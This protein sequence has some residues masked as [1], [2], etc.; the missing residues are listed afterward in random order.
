ML[1][2]FDK[3]TNGQPLVNLK[4]TTGEHWWANLLKFTDLPFISS[5]EVP[6]YPDEDIYYIVDPWNNYASFTQPTAEKPIY[7]IPQLIIDNDVTVLFLLNETIFD[8]DEMYARIK[9]AANDR[10]IK[11]FFILTTNIYMSEK[12]HDVFYYSYFEDAYRYKL[13]DVDI[14]TEI[15][16]KQRKKKF[17]LLNNIDKWERRIFSAI[18]ESHNL[19]EHGYFSYLRNLYN[20]P[21]YQ[22]IKRNRLVKDL[23]HEPCYE[24]ILKLDD[25]MPIFLEEEDMDVAFKHDYIPKY[26]Y[27][28][29]YWNLVVETSNKTKSMAFTE[30]TWKPI[31][32]LQP[33]ILLSGHNSL[34]HLHKLGYRTFKH[35]IDESY[36][37]EADINVRTTAT[38]ET[39]I[40]VIKQ[41]DAW[42][43]EQIR[44]L[45]G[46][47]EHNQKHFFNHK[48]R[49][50]EV[51][52]NISQRNN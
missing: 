9:V 24:S 31:V 10:K 5:T 42:N 8:P 32:N 29:A 17:T 22:N 25:K 38:A 19:L 20:E 50:N 1:F 52:I 43:M 3:I 6:N 47:L 15:N 14:V 34:E 16:T 26:L 49:F 2:A 18:L 33:F 7:N 21:S 44:V 39:A 30:K 45:S 4:D 12:Y 36:A 28:E 37:T 35:C 40:S 48:N 41:D 27:N 13:S 46:I 11:N 23:A 51:L